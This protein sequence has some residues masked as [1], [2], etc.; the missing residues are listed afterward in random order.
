M[1]RGCGGLVL[2]RVQGDATWVFFGPEGSSDPT[3]DKHKAPASAAPRP[4]VPTGTG[5][6]IPLFGC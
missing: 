2:V 5:D 1:M 3:E 4:I 6:V